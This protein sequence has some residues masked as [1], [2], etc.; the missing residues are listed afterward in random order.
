MHTTGAA[1]LFNASAK[2][3]GVLTWLMSDLK[4]QA[5]MGVLMAFIY[6]ANFFGALILLPAL[7]YIFDIKHKEK[8]V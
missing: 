6:I 3:V 1:I 8:T 5:D 4:F 7:V 2:T